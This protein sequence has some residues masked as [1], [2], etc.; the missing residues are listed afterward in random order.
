MKVT[1]LGAAKEVGRSA[2]LV[3]ADGTN[4]LM[5]YGVLLKR[6]PI[7]PMHVKPKDVDAVVISH[8]HL[9]HSGFVPSLFL[10]QSTEVQVLGTFPTFELSQLLIEDMIKISGF[11][12]PFE[13]LDLVTMLNHSRKLEYRDPY[14][15]NDMSISLHE[16]GH[17]LGGS[18]VMLE[19]DGKRL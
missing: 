9:D 18:T 1:V 17:I 13:Y 5:D 8:A 10:S 4:I 19:Y 16:S 12:L 6:E 15:I 14:K 2:F 11:Y 3:N 7:F